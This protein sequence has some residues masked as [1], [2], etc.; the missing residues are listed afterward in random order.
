MSKL[1]FNHL[2]VFKTTLDVVYVTSH[3][4]LWVFTA[5]SVSNSY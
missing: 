3:V 2:E 4:A 5:I 1:K